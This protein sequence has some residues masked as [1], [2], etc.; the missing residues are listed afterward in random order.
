MK[1]FRYLGNKDYDPTNM[2]RSMLD[3]ITITDT[4]GTGSNECWVP[5][6]IPE[7][8]VIA[9]I[10]VRSKTSAVNTGPSS[11]HHSLVHWG[12]IPAMKLKANS[13]YKQKYTAYFNSATAT[14]FTVGLGFKVKASQD[15]S[16]GFAINT[17]VAYVV[18]LV[19]SE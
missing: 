12:A 8:K 19:D 10:L 13:N 17:D 9:A 11:W 18:V 2:L 15:T 1:Y 7:G 3:T 6:N 5:M 4:S 14:S 16:Y